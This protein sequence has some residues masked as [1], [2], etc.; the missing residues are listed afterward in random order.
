MGVI[1]FLAAF[2][3][4]FIS[5]PWSSSQNFFLDLAGALLQGQAVITG[6]KYWVDV[7]YLDPNHFV[8]PFFPMPAIVLIPWVLIGAPPDQ[9]MI[10]SY[11]FGAANSVLVWFVLGQ[12]GQKGWLRFALT[13][14][15]MFGT[16]HWFAASWG[17]PW[18][19]AQLVAVFFL[20]VAISV[21]LTQRH[22][23]LSGI[24]LGLAGLARFQ[25]VLSLPF[26]W[27]MLPGRFYRLSRSR[28][29]LLIGLIFT[30]SFQ[31]FYNWLR[32]GSLFETGYNDHRLLVADHLAPALKA[33]GAFDLSFIPSQLSTMLF[34]LPHAIDCFPY[35]CPSPE[36]LSLFLTSP[37][38]FY[39]FRAWS[40]DRLVLGSWLAVA[41]VLIP[42]LTYY[43]NGWWQFGFRFSLDFAPF[44]LLLTAKGMGN[45][46]TLSA[47]ALIVVSILVNF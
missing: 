25:V 14:F 41:F 12:V 45:K 20:L 13:L 46:L 2:V 31:L 21:T 36:G 44:L 15:F 6:H 19:F 30:S 37:A 16:V 7:I 3:V 33:H 23:L 42:I 18:L 9:W 35:L 26:F 11:L 29:L 32:F 40:T 27:L 38:Y 28:L 39:I 22:P 5:F 4:Y 34:A 10:V 1:L 24:L 43:A 17:S 47:S 8:I